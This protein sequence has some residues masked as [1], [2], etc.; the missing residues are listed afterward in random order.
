[1]S[2]RLR[3]AMIMSA[4]RAPE[5][6]PKHLMAQLG[7]NL[8][9]VRSRMDA[10]EVPDAL[11][12]LAEVE[13][14]VTG[15]GGAYLTDHVLDAMPR[16]RLVVVASG[17]VRHVAG[18]EFWKRDIPIV[19]A[20]AANAVPVIEFSL[21]QIVLG[22]K[23]TFRMARDARAHLPLERQMIDGAFGTTVGV[24]S[25]GAIGRGVLAGLG[26]LDVEV[27]AYDPFAHEV[28]GANLTDLETIFSRAQVVSVH[29]PLLPETVGLVTRDLLRTLPFGATILNTSRG[30]VIDELGLLEVMIDRPDLTAVLDVTVDEPVRLDSPLRDV[31]NIVLTGH[32]AGSLGRERARVGAL[33]VEEIRRF[34]NGE[35]LHHQVD[36]ETA[37]TRA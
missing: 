37:A 29:T 7:E 18:P 8:T 9:W 6:F 22:L 34:T 27:L 30:S 4:D 5:V 36:R 14:L 17:S 13:V 31:A 12:D 23:H 26:R 15:W 2:R 21:A 35:P 25:L 3:A 16:L 32:I 24:L 28:D 19:S 1:M 10:E 20:A 33:A 11:A